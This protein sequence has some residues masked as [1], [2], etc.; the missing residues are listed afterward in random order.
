MVANPL[1][2]DPTSC[3][4]FYVCIN[5]KEPRRNGC[6]QGSVFNPLAKK[7]DHPKNVP[8][9]Y[10]SPLS[11]QLPSDDELNRFSFLAPTSTTRTR[12]KRRKKSSS[13]SLDLTAVNETSENEKQLR[14]YIFL[15]W[16]QMFHDSSQ[17]SFL[18]LISEKSR[19]LIKALKTS[20][21]YQKQID[22][23]IS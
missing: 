16:H 13:K 7:C 1:Y 9:W 11:N 18:T 10:K 4:F 19:I 12:R 20:K 6:P 15:V 23:I 22:R 17:L 3:Q 21:F 8:E 14:Q 2:R 5:N